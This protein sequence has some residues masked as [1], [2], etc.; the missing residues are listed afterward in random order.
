MHEWT[1]PQCTALL[2]STERFTFMHRYL[3]NLIRTSK[4]TRH[5][6]STSTY[7]GPFEPPSI[8]LKVMTFPLPFL[9]EQS[10][11]FS[12][13][14]ARLAMNS[15]TKRIHIASK[16]FAVLLCSIFI[17]QTS[18]PTTHHRRT[19][20]AWLSVWCFIQLLLWLWFAWLR[21]YRRAP[22]TRIWKNIETLT[23][24]K[25]QF[26]VQNTET[27]KQLRGY[28]VTNCSVWIR[29]NASNRKVR[30]YRVET[31]NKNK[32]ELSGSGS[33]NRMNPSWKLP[34]FFHIRVCEPNDSR[35]LVK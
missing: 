15:N 5:W 2:C 20:C 10:S 18:S 28:Y 34:I 6:K 12:H 1:N 35:F 21:D 29:E 31:K 7:A 9:H 17:I 16:A 13:V 27:T 32:T 3:F 11:I 19:H 33:C 23:I 22:D 24:L 30:N 25:Y 14:S 4:M 8:S 26:C